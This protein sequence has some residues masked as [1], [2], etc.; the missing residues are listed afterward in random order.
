MTIL[1]EQRFSDSP[2]IETVTQGYT[3][4]AGSTIR[5][6]ECHWHMVVVRRE[7]KAQLLVVGPLPKAGAVSWGEGAEILWIKFKLGV[8]MPQLPIAHYLDRETVLPA[9]TGRTFWLQGA[10]W[11]LP[12]VE[13]TETFV[14]QLVSEELLV[15]D[16]LVGAA[17][18]DQLLITS[19]RTVRHHF[20]RA[21][22]LPQGTIR[23]MQRAQQAATLL[24]QGVS[25][26]DTVDALGY[27]DQPHLTRSLKQFVGYT[28]G[29]LLPPPSP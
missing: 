11:Q 19:P 9:A 3:P 21:T 6:A 10:T 13:N 27:F 5:P 23:Q 22:G 25:I 24:R 12:T 7:G 17:L 2:L 14:E 29:Q 1:F 18:Q 26:L 28:P 15:I 20:L 8:F 4:C 16:P